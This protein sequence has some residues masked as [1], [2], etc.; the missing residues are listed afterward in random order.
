M[1]RSLLTALFG[2]FLAAPAFASSLVDGDGDA[3][4]GKSITCAA[5]HGAAG[6]S[7]NPEWPSLAGQNAKYI[8]AQLYAFRE[9]HRNNVLMTS[10]A[11]ILDED[12]IND[13]AVY[14]EGLAPEQLSVADPAL[15]ER[16]RKLYIAGDGEQ[17]V[18]ACIACHGPGGKGNPASAYPKIGGQHATYTAKSLRDYASGERR[19]ADGNQIM[20]NIASGLSEDDIVAL[21][22]YIQGLY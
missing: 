6:N 4:K 5:C 7:I 10:Q 22:S 2:L 1:K 9:G 16:G 17:Q 19:S 8:V 3:G 15:V 12:G 20:N 14:Y 11:M 21:A 13:L 18:S